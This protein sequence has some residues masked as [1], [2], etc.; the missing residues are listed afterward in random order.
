MFATNLH[1]LAT[2]H[3]SCCPENSRALYRLVYSL[4]L[5]SL[6]SRA[7]S[8]LRDGTCTVA[9]ITR[10]PEIAVL[11]DIPSGDPELSSLP[12]PFDSHPRPRLHPRGAAFICFLNE[13]GPLEYLSSLFQ[14]DK[15]LVES[16]TWDA[17]LLGQYTAHVLK[18]NVSTPAEHELAF[19]Q[20]NIR[21]LVE[22]ASLREAKEVLSAEVASLRRQV[23][24]AMA[25]DMASREELKLLRRE[26]E[27]LKRPAT[28]D[29]SRGSWVEVVSRKGRPPQRN[30]SISVTLDYLWIRLT[31]SQGC[32]EP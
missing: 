14:T 22:Q 5:L 2:E 18:L 6:C 30:P 27:R 4:T 10:P 21:V 25:A 31:N 3:E 28:P 17:S 16:K 7:F 1:T 8:L 26:I 32:E 24:R 13:E 12:I 11:F 15:A 23:D 9:I 19:Y 29:E 20:A